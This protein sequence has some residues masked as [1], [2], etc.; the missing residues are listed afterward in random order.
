MNLFLIKIY[1][2]NFFILSLFSFNS[3]GNIHGIN[4]TAYPFEIK[5][6]QKQC[7]ANLTILDLYENN[8]NVCFQGTLSTGDKINQHEYNV[9]IYGNALRREVSMLYLNNH[10]QK[11]AI[12]DKL[13]LIFN[14]EMIVIKAPNGNFYLPKELNLSYFIF[15]PSNIQKIDWSFFEMAKKVL[16]TYQIKKNEIIQDE[17]GNKIQSA[18]QIIDRNKVNPEDGPVID[19]VIQ[20]VVRRSHMTLSD[21]AG[22]IRSH[23]YATHTLKTGEGK[24]APLKGTKIVNED[25]SFV[26]AI[27]DGNTTITLLE[28]Q[29]MKTVP[30]Q[31]TDSIKIAHWKGIESHFSEKG[32]ASN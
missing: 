20:D 2:I 17:F 14:H 10:G 4:D 22:F 7:I 32:L 6:T 1:S 27:K 19:V 29:G 24:R 15:N 21:K 3:F 8:V 5:A 18:D 31:V 9:F 28:S 16:D 25:G 23:G 26:L 30:I 13:N 12:Y 11:V